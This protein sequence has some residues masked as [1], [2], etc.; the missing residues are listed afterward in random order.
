MVEATIWEVCA[1]G[2]RHKFEDWI[3]TRGGVQIWVNQDLSNRGGGEIYQPVMDPE[4]KPSEKPRWSH[5]LA[6]T[7]TDI[8][9]FRFCKELRIVDRFRVGIER[10]CGMSL[11]LTGP[12]SRK[13]KAAL[14]KHEGAVY[15]F[16]EIHGKPAAIIMVPEWETNAE[17]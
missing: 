5:A 2:C 12:A 9:R 1:P 17:G 7:I 10:G 11:V 13:L 16:G 8:T 4:G 14:A 15:E 3:G 6:E